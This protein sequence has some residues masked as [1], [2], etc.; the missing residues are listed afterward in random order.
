[1]VGLNGPTIFSYRN[2]ESKDKLKKYIDKRRK[3]RVGV[4]QVETSSPKPVLWY[5]R[6][7]DHSEF[8]T[9]KG[10]DGKLY[11]RHKEWFRKVWIGPYTSTEETQEIIDSYVNTSLKLGIQSKIDSRVHS[12]IIENPDE[13]FV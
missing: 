6:P 12:I 7:L 10:K 2:M 3:M 1:M 5:K 8:L 13:F 11:V 4:S 9:S